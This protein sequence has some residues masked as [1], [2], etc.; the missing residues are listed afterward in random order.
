MTV[1]QPPF[2]KPSTNLVGQEN[3]YKVVNMVFD[4]NDYVEGHDVTRPFE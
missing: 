4:T 3:V 1:M 2:E